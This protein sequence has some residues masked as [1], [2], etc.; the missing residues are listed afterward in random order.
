MC[1][2]VLS[3]GHVCVTCKYSSH[4]SLPWSSCRTNI[5]IAITHPHLTA[6]PGC[7]PYPA[8]VH[9]IAALHCKEVGPS[10]D[11]T[12]NSTDTVYGSV[13]LYSCHSGYTFDA[14]RS[15]QTRCNETGLWSHE[16]GQCRR[17]S[18]THQVAHVNN[19][20]NS[21]LVVDLHVEYMSA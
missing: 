14:G 17:K 9:L 21:G 10:D 5:T 12:V 4:K 2:Y 11:W 7:L 13:V 15:V 6:S 20:C 18:E 3:C 16:H 19:P 1:D 8:V